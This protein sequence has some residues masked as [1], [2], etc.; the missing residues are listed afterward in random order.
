MEENSYQKINSIFGRL[1]DLERELLRLIGGKEVDIANITAS[2][3]NAINVIL[4]EHY[5]NIKDLDEK[6]EI[7]ANLKYY[8]DLM[9][10]L[11]EI[12]KNVELYEKIDEKYFDDLHEFIA[13]KEILIAG[14]YKS[15][16]A[17][18]LS[19]FYDENTR[20]KLESILA[21]KF[22]ARSR[23]FFTIGPLEEEIKKIAKVAGAD[24]VEISPIVGKKPFRSA[25][26]L[27]RF[28]VE[29][30]DK[31]QKLEIIGQELKKYLESKNY[32]VKFRTNSIFT[33]AQLL[34][35]K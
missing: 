19:A 33:D 27:I 20:D 16:S 1:S 12:F 31:R 3:N 11:M 9:K 6:L 22:E 24:E 18:E 13:D 28:D 14:K 34:S 32:R 29:S 30:E 7:R 21:A 4:K 25:R 15:I 2:F 35:D 17:Y 10:I 8:Y 5:P 26:S 23:Q